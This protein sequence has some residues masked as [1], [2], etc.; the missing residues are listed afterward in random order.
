MY[1]PKM[2]H[3]ASEPFKIMVLKHD[4]SVTSNTTF[5]KAASSVHVMLQPTA[6]LYDQCLMSITVVMTSYLDFN[7][8]HIVV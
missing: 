8:N 7:S 4:V 3:R 6:V 2:R 5:G 1:L